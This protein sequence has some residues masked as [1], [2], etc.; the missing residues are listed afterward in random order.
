MDE[1]EDTTPTVNQPRRLTDLCVRSLERRLHVL[2][3]VGKVPFHL[4]KRV[5][6]KATPV[7]LEKLE[8]ASPQI[9]GET[10]SLWRTHCL[11]DFPSTQPSKP[12][13]WRDHY[14]RCRHDRKKATS[15]IGE[16][17]RKM[18]EIGEAE[19]EK[20]KAVLLD[21]TAA[22]LTKKRS[23]G[24]GAAATIS[25]AKKESGLLSK[26]RKDAQ[27]AATRPLAFF[28]VSYRQA[29]SLSL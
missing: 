23:K 19:R 28:L 25:G 5:L 24:W 9:I 1:Y 27:L 17:L 21:A 26:A 14:M 15:S 6:I 2:P 16:K 3:S 13:T 11:R 18:K 7:Q 20:R 10:E 29:C 12:V 4:I 22:T 8:S